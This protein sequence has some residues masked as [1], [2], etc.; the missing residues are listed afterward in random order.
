L[1]LFQHNSITSSAVSQEVNKTTPVISWNNPADITYGT[2][3]SATQLNATSGGVAGTFSYTPAAGTVLNAGNSQ[4]LSVSFV[5]AGVA[6]YNTPAAKAAS[7]NVNKADQAIT[8]AALAA[9]TFGDASGT[10]GSTA[11]S[12]GLSVS[13]ASSN[14]AVATLIGNI[15]TI[16][17]AGSTTINASQAGNTNY[18]PATS[19]E[20]TLTVNKAATAILDITGLASSPAIATETLPIGVYAVKA[21][22]GAACSESIGY[23]S[24][25]DPNAN[26]VT[27]GGWIVSSVGAYV[28]DAFLTGKAN[29]GFSAKYKKASNQVDGNTE[30]Q[31]QAGNFNFK[32]NLLESGTLVISGAKSYLSKCR[33]SERCW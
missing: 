12:S 28:A 17:G 19:V 23:L 7:I 16:V 29:F 18:N 25:Y 2:A 21:V 24:I 27:G 3:L 4:T 9:K 5:P 32:S 11:A 14:T 6:N 1:Q 22:A 26:F 30:F 13:Y 33:N 15:V 10:L 8:F 20:Q 31:F